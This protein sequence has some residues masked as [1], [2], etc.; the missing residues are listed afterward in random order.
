MIENTWIFKGKVV[1]PSTAEY[2]VQ[3]FSVLFT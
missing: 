2:P 1:S 3:Y